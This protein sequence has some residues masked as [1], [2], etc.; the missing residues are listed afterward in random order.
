[1][2][3]RESG[4]RILVAALYAHPLMTW[5]LRDSIRRQ[6]AQA[7][8]FVKENPEWVL[9]RDAIETRKVLAEGK[10]ALILSLEGAAGILESEKDLHEFIDER[11]IRI[12]TLLHLIDDH[13][14][15]AAFLRGA[16]ILANPWAALREGYRRLGRSSSNLPN[17][18]VN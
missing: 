15:G 1:E 8:R 4:I 6:I 16:A 18:V 3:L 13:F 17:P 14:G 12:V 10:R 2:T 11:G 5:D 7:E 9:V